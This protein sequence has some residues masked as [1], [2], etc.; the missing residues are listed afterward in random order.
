MRSRHTIPLASFSLGQARG[1]VK[2]LFSPNPA[3]YW[4]DFMLSLMGGTICFVLMRRVFEPFSLPALVAFV[5]C[6][7][8]YYRA[9]LFTHELVHLRDSR[10]RSFSIAWNLFCGIPFLAPTFLYYIHIDHHTRSH[11][12]TDKDGEYLPLGAHSPIHILIYLFQPFVIPLLAVIRF[13]VLTPLCWASSTVRDLVRR[14]ASSMVMDPTYVRPLPTRKTVRIIRLQETLCFLWCVGIATA[15]LAGILPIEVLVTTYCLSV[16]ILL[17]NGLRTL[18]AHRYVGDGEEMTFL[19]QLLDSI[20]YPNRPFLSALWAP[21][22]LRFHALHHLF[23]SMPYHNLD[24]AHRRL[25]AKLPAESP[26]RMT[27]SP[28]LTA[29]LIDLWRRSQAIARAAGHEKRRS[30][31]PRRPALSGSSQSVTD[32]Q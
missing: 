28:S 15:L 16:F 14:R 18:G 25:I 20:N 12:G 26:Y 32:P 23:P 13:G 1:I 24:R 4:A 30:L 2:D 19:E 29:A 21:V 7:L 17:L 27:E 11:F 31:A 22:G 8:C 10:F 6:G 9:V 5:M 3:I